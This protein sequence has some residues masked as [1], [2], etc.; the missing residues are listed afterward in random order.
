MCS[1]DLHYPASAD[2]QYLQILQM[3]A[4]ESEDRVDAVLRYQVDHGLPMRVDAVR[5]RMADE[6]PVDECDP[7]RIAPPD[8]GIY[9]QLLGAE[10]VTW[11]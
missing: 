5:E 8:I 6:T 10:E 3:A 9:D 1:S 4:L 7:V 2:R 11:R